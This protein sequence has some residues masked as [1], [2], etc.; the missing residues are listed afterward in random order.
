MNEKILERFRA[1]LGWSL[2]PW[3]DVVRGIRD[4]RED[5]ERLRRENE[6]L[7]GALN[8]K[9][10][11]RREHRDH[12]QAW[13]DSYATGGD[14]AIRDRALWEACTRELM[15]RVPILIVT[16]AKNTNESNAESEKEK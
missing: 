1:A 9:E 14:P 10:R 4:L 13:A 11:E 5:A 16:P 3:E 12:M 15:M 6:M 2:V 8:V 7:L